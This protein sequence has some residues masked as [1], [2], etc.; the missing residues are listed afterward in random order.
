MDGPLAKLRPR[1]C[2]FN[3]RGCGASITLEKTPHRLF[4][5]TLVSAVTRDGR[6]RCLEKPTPFLLIRAPVVG[7]GV[8]SK[9]EEPRGPDLVMHFAQKPFFPSSPPEAEFCGANSPVQAADNQ[10]KLASQAKIAPDPENPVN[11]ERP[12]ITPFLDMKKTP[13]ICTDFV[14]TASLDFRPLGSPKK[15]LS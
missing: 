1:N 13:C 5:R 8:V 3:R 9:G 10:Q 2:S 15:G 12:K 11:P 6:A 14:V 7:R 4:L